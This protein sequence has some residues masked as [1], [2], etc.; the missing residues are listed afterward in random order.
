[1]YIPARERALLLY[2]LETNQ[3][4]TIK[5]IASTLDVSE[6]TIHRDLKG[7]DDAL[8]SFHL[9]LETK[10]GQGI[11]LFGDSSDRT[12]L[13][14]QLM[15]SHPLEY[16]KEERI[17]IILTMLFSTSEPT[18]LIALASD[19]NVTIAT[20]SND[21][22]DVAS[23][24]QDYH[25]E[26]VRKRGYGVII[27]GKEEYKRAALKSLIA[28]YID[29]FE[30]VHLF[31]TKKNQETMTT[32]FIAERLLDFVNQETIVEIEANVEE[33][34]KAFDIVLADNAYIGL[35]VH[36]A[37]AV[38]R[39]KSG[40]K[41]HFDTK[42]LEEI[43]KYDEFKV[44][45][46][47]IERLKKGLAIEM[48]LDEIGY[49]TMHLLGAKLRESEEL[50]I[51]EDSAIDIAMQ[52][53]KLIQYV[54]QQYD[55]NFQND[56]RLL[57]DLVTHLKP[58][59][60][61]IKRGMKIVNPL[62]QDVEEKY[63]KLM[64]VVASGVSLT[65]PTLTFP[66][67]EIGYLVMHFGAQLYQK[68]KAQ[69]IKA[70]VICSSGIGTAR[71]LATR[72]KQNFPEVTAVKTISMLS[73][74][75]VDI[76]QFDMVLSTIKLHQFNHPY[77]IVSP[78]LLED[79]LVEIE[80]YIS[81]ISPLKEKALKKVEQGTNYQK[82]LSHLSKQAIITQAIVDHLQINSFASL[83]IDELIIQKCQAL[84]TQNMIEDSQTLADDLQARLDMGGLAI[85]ELSMALFHTRSAVVK[86]PHFSVVNLE[87]PIDLDGMDGQ[88]QAVKTVLFMLAN[89]SVSEDELTL[90]SY[91]SSL[92]IQ[93][94]SFVT[95]L[96]EGNTS[97]VK[98]YLAEIFYAYI[99][100]N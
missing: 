21:L 90:L 55:T 34:F 74:Q 63:F 19:L 91:L 28:R 36:L 23:Q 44:A 64:E 82:R 30:V 48:P 75:D 93:D 79:E 61:R 13:Q 45:E 6:R 37:L 39:L 14:K 70:L 54:G 94:D 12:K 62:L 40:E 25:L 83:T 80:K 1:M 24:L 29:P 43:Q 50:T 4:V 33:V 76:S 49:I 46:L 51:A 96:H 27:Q 84:E 100:K 32:D 58:A 20:V 57:S 53:R 89:D 2:L 22:D 98:N 41:I 78:M 85:P 11:K 3:F 8:M 77:I 69:N 86:A 97:K 88:K 18:K 31:K 65:F 47:L 59:L 87:N 56:S 60:F 81:Q 99:L 73:I 9:K 42:Y 66:R 15:K 5:D 71:I 68:I 72:L 38:Q 92:L 17:T 16:T 10:K 7:I 52:V 67:D 95:L 26:L 35:V